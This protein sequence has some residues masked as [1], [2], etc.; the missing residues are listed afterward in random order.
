MG[1]AANGDADG[2]QVEK[3][4]VRLSF[5]LKCES[6][7]RS[8]AS[9]FF[10]SFDVSPVQG[11]PFVWGVEIKN[12]SE[13]PSPE[14]EILNPYIVNL[15]ANYYEESSRSIAVRSLNPSECI[16]VEM[17]KCTLYLDGVLWAKF[18]VTS[19]NDEYNVFAYQIDENH[20]KFM[21]CD[22]DDESKTNW[23]KDV[24]V[25]RKSEVLQSRTN[26]LIVILTVVTV[27]EAVFK[28]K[29]C[30]R[31]ALWVMSEFFGVFAS[32]FS[33]LRALM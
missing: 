14:I 7:K 15:E 25:H 12:I 16:Y 22:Y 2:E 18:L 11:E 13:F 17:D 1:Q 9:R 24:Y 32:L 30:L 10:R 8:F 19:K 31:F 6:S 20:N 28:I 26:K 27:V 4:E 23:V 3:K 21:R 33:Y 5:R 29:E